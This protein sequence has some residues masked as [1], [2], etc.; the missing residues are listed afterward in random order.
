[1][2]S[3]PDMMKKYQEKQE[4]AYKDMAQK[5]GYGP[6]GAPKQD[7]ENAGTEDDLRGEF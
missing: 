2:D 6:E 3:I 4:N 7:Q 1:M 5:A